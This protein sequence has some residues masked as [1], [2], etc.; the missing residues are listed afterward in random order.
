[1]VWIVNQC[2]LKETH[3][4]LLA[5]VKRTAGVVSTARLFVILSKAGVSDSGN[6]LIKAQGSCFA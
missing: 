1:M 6:W 3:Y 5:S 4:L 2:Q